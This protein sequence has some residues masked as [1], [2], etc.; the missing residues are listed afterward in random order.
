MSITSGLT[1]QFTGIQKQYNNLRAEILDATD[2]VLRSGNL[3]SGNC[4]TEFENWLC[5][6]NHVNY[7][8]TCHSGTQALE[9]IAEYY[10]EWVSVNPPRVLLPAMS[11]PATANAWHRAGWNI[12]FVDVDAYGQMNYGKIDRQQSIQAICIVGLYGHAVTDQPY[13]YTDWVI[14][15]GA[16]HWLADDCR[17][18]GKATAISFDPTKN[19]ANYG[20]G[21]AVITD[22]R[23][24]ADFARDWVQHGKKTHH[25]TAGSNSRMSEVDCAQMTVKTRYIDAWQRR[26]R[27]IAD[28]WITMLKDTP[29]RCLID[30]K[31]FDKHCF[32]KFVIDVDNRD[33]LLKDLRLRG[34]ETKIHYDRPLWELPVFDNTDKSSRFLANAAALT[35]RCLSLPI[36]PELTDLEVEY[37]I[38]RLLEIVS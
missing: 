5:K 2:I 29:V 13:Y 16:Q 26:R 12:E 6:K 37:I 35:R 33:Q 10:R 14:E 8:V 20:N 32:H 4:T 30:R 19:L 9:I 3:M 22:D 21:G 23:Q 1:I 36:Y 24:L 28:H 11:F 31:N 38:D 15:D 7:A 18:R 34:I 25:T 17:R 27:D